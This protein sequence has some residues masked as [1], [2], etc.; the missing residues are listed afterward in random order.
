MVPEDYAQDKIDAGF[1]HLGHIKRI[2]VPK[3]KKMT[4]RDNRMYYINEYQNLDDQSDAAKFKSL[5]EELSRDHHSVFK[6]NNA[7][8]SFQY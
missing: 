5:Y 8:N 3:I 7:R 2:S 1:S 6:N 4:S